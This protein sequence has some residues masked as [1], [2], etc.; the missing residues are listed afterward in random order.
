MAKAGSGKARMM[1]ERKRR[2]R[3]TAASLRNAGKALSVGA[4][5]FKKGMKKAKAPKRT[6]Q[7]RYTPSAPLSAAALKVRLIGIAVAV[8]GGLLSLVVAPLGALFFIVGIIAAAL[9]R[10]I[11]ERFEGGI[12]DE[13]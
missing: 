13:E 7:R 6:A 12:S 9:A 2:Q 8:A 3:A 1:A 5:S 10:R 11:A 4:R